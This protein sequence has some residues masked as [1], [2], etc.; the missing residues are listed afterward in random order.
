MNIV[1]FSNQ[2]LVLAGLC[3]FALLIAALKA[4]LE[5]VHVD[6]PI[7][8]Y[9]AKRFAE[10]HYLINYIRHADEIVAQID[11]HWPVPYESFSESYWRFGRLGHIAIL[12]TIVGFLGS[13]YQAIL[14][15]TWLYNIFLV[16]GLILIFLS[17]VQIGC[18]AE[19]KYRWFLGATLSMM[20]FLLSD[21]YRYLAG[22][23]VSEVPSIL[24]VGA[25]VFSLLRAFETRRLI[26]AVMSGLF[27]FLGYTMRIESIW[28]WLTFIIAYFATHGAGTHPFVSLKPVL[29]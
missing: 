10:T 13:S 25:S 3:I 8:L 28:S 9:Q 5:D 20:M 4:P 14:T 26:F 21:I 11:G 22:N 7:Y 17:S 18:R 15:S 6:A 1:N 16:G 27:A 19:P 2:K 24:F 12:G 23:L 29:I